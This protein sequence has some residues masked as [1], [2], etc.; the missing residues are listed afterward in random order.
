M[1]VKVAT[2][3]RGKMLILVVRMNE[4]HLFYEFI[5]YMTRF[6]PFSKHLFVQKCVLRTKTLIT[7]PIWMLKCSN[8]K[9]INPVS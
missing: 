7:S 4:I 1:V 2:S 6:K 8:F 5:H 9:N 3:R